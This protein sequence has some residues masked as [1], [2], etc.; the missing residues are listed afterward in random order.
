MYKILK[1]NQTFGFPLSQKHPFM[2]SY[3]YPIC[4]FDRTGYVILRLY[5][6]DKRKHC[7]ANFMSAL[8]TAILTI[9]G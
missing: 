1:N 5:L 3:R 6:V 4:C 8:R 2:S 7:S 9:N